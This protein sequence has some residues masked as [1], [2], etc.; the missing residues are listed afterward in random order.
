MPPAHPPCLPDLWGMLRQTAAPHLSD[1]PC[2]VYHSPGLQCSMVADFIHAGR[3]GGSATV[4]PCSAHTT[5]APHQFRGCPD[6]QQL[7][8]HGFAVVL[9]VKEHLVQTSTVELISM[10]FSLKWLKWHFSWAFKNCCCHPWRSPT[11]NLPLWR[12]T[13]WLQQ[14]SGSRKRGMIDELC[15]LE[16]PSG[17]L[18]PCLGNWPQENHG[19][20]RARPEEGHK[21]VQWAGAPL[22]KAGYRSWGCGDWRREDSGEISF[23]LSSPWEVLMSRKESGFLHRMCSM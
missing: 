19:A 5:S 12:W 14:R 8:S 10:S 15:P 11:K 18:C 21:A 6:P 22:T 16:V 20:I 13:F 1:A 2:P 3:G 17:V 7:L 23:Q 4:T 9:A